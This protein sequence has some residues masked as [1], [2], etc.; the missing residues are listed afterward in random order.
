MTAEPWV[1]RAKKIE[2]LAAA[3]TECRG[4]PLFLDTTQTVFGEGRRRADMILVGEQPGDVEDRRGH[5]FVGPAGAVLWKCLAEAGIERD[6]IYVTNAV[7]HFKHE[8][9]GKRRI[10]K[11]PNA[12]EIDACH[13]WL[14]AELRVVDAPVVVAMGAVAARSLTGKSLAIAANRERDLQLDTDGREPRTLVVTYHPSAV[15]RADDRAAEIRAA[16][17]SDLRRARE[18]ATRS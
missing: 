5:V 10:H 1:P 3:A 16:L 11:K 12:A 14:A 15:L 6:R 7:K 4:C 17:V 13:P 8:D 18:L 9:R 2:T